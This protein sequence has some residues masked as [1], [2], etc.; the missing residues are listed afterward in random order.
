M[1]ITRRVF[2]KIIATAL[3]TPAVAKMVPAFIGT[4]S[5]YVIKED[6]TASYIGPKGDGFTGACA[7]KEVKDWDGTGY[8]VVVYKNTFCTPLET[9]TYYDFELANFQREV[10]DRFWW[11]PENKKY[12]NVHTYVLEKR[13]GLTLSEAIKKQQIS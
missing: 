10:P 8:P 1:A 13:F 5:S 7:I 4:R 3:A 11:N 12:P 9:E 6:G 2:L